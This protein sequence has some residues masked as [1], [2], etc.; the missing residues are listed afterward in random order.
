MRR[1]LAC[2]A[3][4]AA[5]G[6][7]HAYPVKPH[8]CAADPGAGCIEKTGAPGV[9]VV[10]N[11]SRTTVCAVHL[12]PSAAEDWTEPIDD[13]TSFGPGQALDFQ[14]KPAEWDLR[15]TDCKGLVLAERNHL[16]LGVIGEGQVV[17]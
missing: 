12:R 16:P 4:T 15:A 2:A 6:C 13:S 9:L 3:L 17:A 10:R 7:R 8:A 1:L 11:F 14:V 5:V